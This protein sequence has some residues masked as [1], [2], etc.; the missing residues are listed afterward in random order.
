MGLPTRR[1][2]QRPTNF[3]LS[4]TR[5][6]HR[7]ELRV[8]VSELTGTATMLV[9]EPPA[10]LDGRPYDR[11][12]QVKGVLQLHVGGPQLEDMAK[13]LGAEAVQIAA[14]FHGNDFERMLAKIGYG[15]AIAEYG[16]ERFEEVYVLRSILG[17]VD[18]VGMWVGCPPD[19]LAD[20]SSNL[21]EATVG[22]SGRD[23]HVRVRLFASY[24]GPWYHIVVGRLKDGDGA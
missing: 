20:S 6:G 21:H 9:L 14:T 17:E 24:R 22:T 2:N 3:S 12:V 16:V 23:V 7:D 15:F 4:I 8:P 1:L 18:D 13:A 10:Y 11:G 5:S 19:L